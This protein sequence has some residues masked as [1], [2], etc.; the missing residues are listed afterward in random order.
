M[1][2]LSFSDLVSDHSL[3][4]D[5]RGIEGVIILP[6]DKRRKV[7]VGT[8]MSTESGKS[9]EHEDRESRD[10]YQAK[11]EAALAIASNTQERHGAIYL[12]VFMMTV[13]CQ[14]GP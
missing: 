4:K 6:D 11:N 5:D 14:S 7:R 8:K 9:H 3:R 13:V 12:F 1:S 10:L 2:F